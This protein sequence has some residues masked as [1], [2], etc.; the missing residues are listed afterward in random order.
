MVQQF[1]VTYEWLIIHLINYLWLDC[2]GVIKGG[3]EVVAGGG[4]VVLVTI[5]I[6]IEGTK[7]Q[8]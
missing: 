7:W 1:N 2:I 5:I 6:I 3:G 8:C 4:G